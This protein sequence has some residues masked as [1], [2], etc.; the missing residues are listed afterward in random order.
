MSLRLIY[1]FLISFLLAFFSVEAAT[2][3]VVSFNILAAPWSHP[4][5][6]PKPCAPYL[7]RILRRE[8][9]LNILR[10][11]KDSSDIIC[12]QEVTPVEFG[13]IENALNGFAGLEV[14]HE[15]HY[16]SHYIVEDPPWEPN[17]TAIFV[18]SSAFDQISFRDLSLSGNGNHGSYV[19][20]IHQATKKRVRAIC[21]HLDSDLVENRK[22]EMQA[23]IDELGPNCG[24]I[25][26][27]VGDYNPSPHLRNEHENLEREGYLDLLQA[28]RNSK[29]TFSLTPEGSHSISYGQ[30]DRISVR[31][32]V[33]LSGDVIDCDLFNLYPVVPDHLYEAARVSAGLQLLGSD[34]FPIWGIVEFD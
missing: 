19:D 13:F 26:L 22:M 18:K 15:P 4:S 7:D 6:Y 21:L 3:K 11:L 31:N 1:A 33:P 29:S 14:H 2:L 16:W 28:I 8:A 27:I 32:A 25:D 12:L 9:I 5:I 23:A 34:H 10:D 30:L 17:G 24:A 20:A